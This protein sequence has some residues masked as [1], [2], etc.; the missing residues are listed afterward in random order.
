MGRPK[1]IIGLRS[2]CYFEVRP[3]VLVRAF[4]GCC[5]QEPLTTAW[6]VL[7]RFTKREGQRSFRIPTMLNTTACRLTRS[8]P[9]SSTVS[10]LPSDSLRRS[11]NG[12]LAHRPK[13]RRETSVTPAFRRFTLAPTAAERCGNSMKRAYFVL[14]AAPP[15]HM[16]IARRLPRTNNISSPH[17]GLRFA[18]SRNAASCSRV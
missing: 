14:G 6:P 5:F 7:S 10:F 16:A 13:L 2:T 17:Y 8:R 11:Y 15:M 3:R 12:H 9:G 1:T 18:R 4:A